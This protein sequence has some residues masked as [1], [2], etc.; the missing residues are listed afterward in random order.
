M[1]HPTVWACPFTHYRGK[2]WSRLQETF[3]KGFSLFPVESNVKGAAETAK[4]VWETLA[5]RASVFSH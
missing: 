3:E 1:E 4:E 2:N 5:V